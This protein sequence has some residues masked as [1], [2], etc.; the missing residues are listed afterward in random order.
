VQ[1]ARHGC[2]HLEAEVEGPLE[3][4]GR[5]GRIRVHA[6]PMWGAA[7]EKVGSSRMALGNLEMPQCGSV[8]SGNCL[9]WMSMH[10]RFPFP[11]RVG[12]RSRRTDKYTDWCAYLFFFFFF[13]G[14]GV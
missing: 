8:F 7:S 4:G 13:G 12:F 10:L 2:L 3:V 6:C 9:A 5:L 14:T 1:L 11:Q